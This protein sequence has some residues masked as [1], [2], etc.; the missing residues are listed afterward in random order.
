MFYIVLYASSASITIIILCTFPYFIRLVMVQISVI[1][2]DLSAHP[3]I[4]YLF[5]LPPQVQ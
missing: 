5:L 1:I 4:L 3:L 2:R